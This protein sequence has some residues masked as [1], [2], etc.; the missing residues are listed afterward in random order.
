MRL[1][2]FMVIL[3][4]VL[5]SV[6]FIECFIFF[7]INRLAN[8]M[9]NI[10]KVS[11]ITIHSDVSDDDKEKIVR[12]SSIQLF[13]LLIMFIVKI[14]VIALIIIGVYNM[15][16]YIDLNSRREIYNQLDSVFLLVSITIFS[17]IYIFLRNVIKNKL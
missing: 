10:A 4:Y 11:I 14:S 17:S 15:V 12:S 5:S 9:F 2:K 7:K 8:E 6:I 1:V 3:F 13:K 16:S